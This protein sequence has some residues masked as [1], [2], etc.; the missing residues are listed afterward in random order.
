MAD[1]I[2]T[3]ASVVTM[4]PAVPTAQAVAVRAG[5]IAAVGSH[6]EVIE[7][8][9]P[10]TRV[11]DLPGAMIVPGFQDSHIHA[12]EGGRVR[13]L[14]NLHEAG[15]AGAYIRIVR[16]YAAAH[17]DREWILGGGWRLDAF[18]GGSPPK[19]LLDAVVSDRPVLLENRD[20]H[21]AW[22]NSRALELAGV[23]AATPDPV[24]GRIERE[25][26]GS[27]AGAL[28]EGAMRLVADHAPTASPG[29]LEEALTE[30]QSYLHSLGITGWQDAIVEAETLAAYRSLAA[31]G[32][33]KARV[34]AALW[35]DRHR[36]LDQVDELVERRHAGTTGRLRATAVKI[37]QDGIPENF[38]AA[39]TSPYLGPD[40]RPGDGSG[41][42]FV[43][44]T[45]LNRAVTRLDAEG[46]Q[47]HVH[48]IGDRA[49]REAL[50]AF[51]AARDANGPRD[52]RHHIAHIQVVH[53]DDIP[54]FAALDVVAN[55]QPYWACL[56]GQMRSLVIPFLGPERTAW[57]YPFASLLRTGATLAMGSDWPVTTPHPLREIQ[58]AVTRIPDGD[59]EQP[60]FLPDERL[61]LADALRAFTSGTAFVNHDD[62]ETGS[63]EPGK[64]ANLAVVDRDLFAI[65]A[66]EIG[67]AKVVLT[68]VEGEP[69]YADPAVVSW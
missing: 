51:E 30:A 16:D 27:P 57:Q 43:E 54:R 56:D 22:A 26:D 39:M 6:D 13:V 55:A 63:I 49:V 28:H 61:A 31:D 47:V 52:S 50:D 17:P 29:E 35:W 65:D 12:I 11:I 18:P 2:L 36:E 8:R 34:V 5:R 15:D 19:G 53:P 68:L 58:V 25:P 66:I 67:T 1:L 33:L 9:G 21:D 7:T 41:L 4:D 48:A 40:G 46:F 20:G 45:L 69:V 32:R 60:V 23:T 42:S 37:M 62:L 3:G 64:L 10:N 59:P 24:D 38:T 14:C 44:P